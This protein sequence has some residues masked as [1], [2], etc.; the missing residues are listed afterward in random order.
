VVVVSRLCL[1]ELRSASVRRE[2][3]I[4]PWFPEPLIRSD[5]PPTDPA[6]LVT[7][8]E[9]VR[10]ALLIVLECMSP[11]ERVVFVLHDVFDFPFE[12][13]ALMVGR[14]VAACRQLA[15]RARR[16][17][18]DEAGSLRF[19]IDPAEQRRVVD[20]F[21]AA[22]AMGEL[23][24][25]LP[26]L[27]PSVMGWAD[28]GGVLPA[29]SQPNV[30][31]EKV[32]QN[33][34]RFFGAESGNRLVVQEINGEPAVV[35]FFEGAVVAVLALSVKEHLITRIYVISDQRKLAQVKRVLEQE[36]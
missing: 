29:V 1:D 4:G 15:S 13:V 22:C 14:S 34:M 35:A 5:D 33:V 23:K 25:L 28:L 32:A 12:K 11:A 36:R 17:I 8:D 2:A 30:G 27:D 10:L 16:R 24:A 18:K 31:I 6:D 9:S 19:A 7:L 3:Y 21:T 20:A 26:L